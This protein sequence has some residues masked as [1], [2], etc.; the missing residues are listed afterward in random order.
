MTKIYLAV[1]ACAISHQVLAQELGTWRDDEVKNCD[2]TLKREGKVVYEIKSNCK[3]KW[4]VGRDPMKVRGRN[5]FAPYPLDLGNGRKLKLSWF[6]KLALS[7]DLELRD[8][9]G[10]IRVLE[11]VTPKTEKQQRIADKSRG[12]VIGM[13]AEQVLASSWG[14]PSKVNRT[15]T[16]NT[17]VEQWVYPGGYLYLTDGVLTG[18]QN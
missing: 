6:Y 3:E 8:G 11:S 2:I 9:E 7:G 4:A 5:E 1:L 10:L 16:K 15:V 12:V 13:R 14:K 18:I 17:Q